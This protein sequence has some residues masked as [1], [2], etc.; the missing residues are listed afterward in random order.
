MNIS[1]G[2]N[3]MASTEVSL[4][5]AIV[6]RVEAVMSHEGPLT[7]ERSVVVHIVIDG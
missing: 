4:V 1:N 7:A 3:D 2:N 5:K 6:K